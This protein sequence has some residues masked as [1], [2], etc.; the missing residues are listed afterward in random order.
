MELSLLHRLCG[1]SHNS[2]VGGRVHI[3]LHGTV[4]T[5]HAFIFSNPIFHLPPTRKNRQNSIRSTMRCHPS[6]SVLAFLAT[7]HA[8]LPRSCAVDPCLNIDMMKTNICK[9][10][11]I[12][13]S[14]S[15]L[16]S[17][18]GQ[19]HSCAADLHGKLQEMQAR[20]RKDGNAWCYVYCFVCF[21]LLGEG[22]RLGWRK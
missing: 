8:S 20:C 22:E 7:F 10:I 11:C 9:Y 17:S 21:F 6:C 15:C 16:Y 14:S 5:I 13:L 1:P 4:L 2:K 12:Y 18:T 3:Y 19:L